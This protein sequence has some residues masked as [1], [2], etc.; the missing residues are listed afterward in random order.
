M[1]YGFKIDEE[2]LDG[3]KRTVG[4]L[5]FISKERI[6][7][8]L[9]K[10]LLTDKPADAI[11]MLKD[12]GALKYV[13]PELEATVGLGQNAFHH[14]DVFSHSM[15]V[16]SK[17]K[18]TLISRISSLLHDI[19]KVKTKEVIDG[20]IHFYSHESVGAEDAEK[21]LRTLKYPDDIIKPV[22]LGIKNH[23][24]LK[25][26]G[27]EG[28]IVSDKALRKFTVDLG[29]HLEDILNMMH[30]DNISHHPDSNMPNQIPGILKRINA[31]KSSIPA[32]NAKL[33]VTGE[34]LKALKI[35]AGPIYKEILDAIRDAI[36]ENPNLTRGEAF[37]IVQNILKNK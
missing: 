32:K 33:P 9:N 19:G 22:V 20:D 23:M 13:I 5:Q 31:L 3:M 27:K 36:Y 10:M 6:R 17:T 1:K 7:D 11:R 34:D 29:D 26:S 12:I 15:S 2:T 4:E 16:L 30:S 18:P 37:T 25:R 35:P 24:R 28:E 14:E 8:E 21:I